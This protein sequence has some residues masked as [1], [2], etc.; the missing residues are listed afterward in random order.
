M[1]GHAGVKGAGGNPRIAHVVDLNNDIHYKL[2]VY[3]ATHG[4]IWHGIGLAGDMLTKGMPKLG[5]MTNA[6]ER[7]HHS[8]LPAAIQ[9][10]ADKDSLKVIVNWED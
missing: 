7:F 9:R 2:Q 5:L 10:A 1:D 8:E 3:Q 6:T 4:S